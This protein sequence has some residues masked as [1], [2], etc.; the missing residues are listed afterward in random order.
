MK[1]EKSHGVTRTE[2]ILADLC[3]KTFLKLWSYPNPYKEDSKE[4]CDLLAVFENHV[5]VF[6]VREAHR[7]D[8][9]KDTPPSDKDLKTQWLRWK[10]QV[11]DK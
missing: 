4:M 5:F 7:F 6:F 2:E 9:L 10:R 8:K 3:E 11:I 1:I